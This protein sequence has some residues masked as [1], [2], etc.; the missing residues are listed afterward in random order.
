MKVKSFTLIEVLIASMIFATVVI[1]GSAS[2]AIIKRSQD[3][4]SDRITTESCS[5]EISEF[6]KS[7]INQDDQQESQI[8]AIKDKKAVILGGNN[9]IISQGVGRIKKITSG[10][11]INTILKQPVVENGVTTYGYIAKTDVLPSNSFTSL[12]AIANYNLDSFLANGTDLIHSANCQALGSNFAQF[13]AFESPFQISSKLGSPYGPS[14]VKG[15]A[16]WTITVDDL[17]FI[18]LKN[19]V[20]DFVKEKNYSKLFLNQT[21]DQKNI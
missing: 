17:I 4:T 18:K 12:T 1:V 14:S 20:T 9:S 16:S 8:F 11:E 3:S 15:L 2:M 21:N 19:R 7:R 5:N 13:T 10:W 6:I